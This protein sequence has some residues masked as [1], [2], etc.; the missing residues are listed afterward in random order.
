[1]EKKAA[2]KQ[3]RVRPARLPSNRAKRDSF[4]A[5]NILVPLDFSRASFK[6]VE[7]A[8][9]LAKRFGGKLNVL[10]ALDYDYPVS[11][12]SALPVGIPETETASRAQR[13]LQDVAK[14]Y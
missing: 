4:K 2:P 5:Y 11:G 3:R 12:F 9:P 6:A 13:R 7:Y 1:M 8:L 14:K 10:H